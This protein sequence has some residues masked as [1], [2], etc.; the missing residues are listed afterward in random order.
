[1]QS[2]CEVKDESPDFTFYRNAIGRQNNFAQFTE[3][4]F[5]NLP[6]ARAFFDWSKFDPRNIHMAASTMVIAR[7]VSAMPPTDQTWLECGTWAGSAVCESNCLPCDL[8]VRDGS[9]ACARGECV[10]AVD[11]IACFMSF[12]LADALKITTKTLV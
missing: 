11:I 1:M 2:V 12:F 10:V 4:N 8:E 5:T 9:M 3:T 6:T 7:N